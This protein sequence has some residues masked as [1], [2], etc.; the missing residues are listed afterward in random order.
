MDIRAYINPYPPRFSELA[1]FSTITEG[2]TIYSAKQREALIRSVRKGSIVEVQYSFLLAT[3]QGRVKTRVADFIAMFDEI[4]DRGGT[5][6]ETATGRRS[7][8]RK[9]RNRMMIEAREA[10]GTGKPHARFNGQM[11][12]GRPQHRTKEDK[13][14]IEA[15]WHSKKFKTRD[16]A[17]AAIK[18]LGFD[19]PI[20]RGY[21]Y[22]HFGK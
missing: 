10:I 21:C 20:T 6:V 14:K 5:I 11:S 9:D 12:K 1:Q 4:E 17:L 18:A 3:L 13:A 19:P 15:L 8:K 16:D 7:D 2:A 22:S